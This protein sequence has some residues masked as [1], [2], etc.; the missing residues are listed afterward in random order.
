MSFGSLIRDSKALNTADGESRPPRAISECEVIE[1]RRYNQESTSKGDIESDIRQQFKHVWERSLASELR[2]S[3]IVAQT[4]PSNEVFGGVG[5]MGRMHERRS[6]EQRASPNNSPILYHQ[7]ISTHATK[8]AKDELP[9]HKGQRTVKTVKR[10]VRSLL[11]TKSFE[12]PH[13]RLRRKSSQQALTRNP[14]AKSSKSSKAKALYGG[15]R[16]K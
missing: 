1:G 2:S 4:S 7:F 10:I 11:R 9:S 13:Y 3:L 12:G 14:S 6:S 16:R 5:E 8:P 15:S